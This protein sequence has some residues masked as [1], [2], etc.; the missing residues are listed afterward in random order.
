MKRAWKGLFR[1]GEAN[2]VKIVCLS[3]G[4]AIGLVMLAEVIFER[5]YDNFLPGL[6]ETYRVEERYKQKD[7][8]WREHAQ[9]PGA[10]GPGL[11][12][13]CPAVEVATRFTGI[14]SMTLTTE[15]HKELEGQAWFCDST[16][17]RVFPR[18]LLMGEEPYTGL[19]KANNAYISSKLLEVAG[20]Q[21]I[22]KTLS[23]KQYPEFH[24][25]VVGV[26]EAFP[27]NT[28]LPQMD[29]LIALPTIGQVAYD[30]TNN[31][32]GNDRYKT[33]VRLR[34]GT[35]PDDLKEG[36]DRML[37]ANHVTEELSQS[38]TNLEFSLRPVAEIF[39]SSDYN[40]IMNI[41]FL[42]FAIIMLLV[43]VLNYILL[44]VSSMVSRAKGIAT[45]RCYGAG[46]GDIYRMILS[47]SL[48]H[49]L[50]S[51]ALAVLI[52]F[53]LQDFL[54]EQIGHSLESLFPLSTVWVCLAV[55]LGVILLCGVMPGYLYTRIPVTYAYR[56]YTENKRR[57]K[58]G[59]LCLQFALTAFFVCLLAVIGLEYH[60]LMNFNPGFEYRNTL[61][62]NLS[63]TEMVER[64][65]CVQELK[66]LPEVK[67]V[68]WG[69]QLLS[70]HC[71]GNNVYNPETGEEYMNIADMYYVGPDYHKAFQIPVVEGNVF[72][73]TLTDTLSQQVMVSRRFV[74]RM[75]TLAGWTG[76]PIGK[77]V[78]ITEH[79]DH[80]TIAIV[81]GVYE[82]IHLGSQVMEEYDERPTVMFYRNKPSSY[83][84]VAL[85][86]MSPEAM[87]EVQQVIDRTISSQ[88]LKVYSLSLE[89]GNLYNAVLHVRNSV[90][91]AGLC[92]LIIALTGLVAYVRDEVSRRRSEIAI[93][94]IHGASMADVQKIFLLDLLKIALPAVVI[95]AL[96]AW[97]VGEQLLQLFAVK[98]D[99]TW[100][101]FAGCILIVCLVV[102]LVA[103]GMVW[104]AAR[105]NPTENLKT[106]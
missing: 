101:L 89:M 13:Y 48:L 44:V 19:E 62:T 102:W 24:V 39:T 29:V 1:K 51:L 61:Y 57:W 27:E 58:L 63:G 21:I 60:T 23:W 77:T 69:Y 78:Y 97:K 81:C 47:E 2:V 71:S 56:R 38:G 68:T 4:L 34:E 43:A 42:S 55:T 84:Y 6:K 73:P 67:A 70:D 30:G 17:F 14:G 9:T 88:Q 50:I 32:L 11:Q 10:I 105:A 5:S 93:R 65:R 103:F 80:G 86:R 16:F 82:D 8:D 96:C 64:E 66:K 20:E 79:A 100:Y 91:F 87:K 98:I 31:W 49:G 46:S 26:F 85:N 3:V 25:T 83:L 45:Y 94:L 7:T 41:V 76:S 36:M 18:K 90:L 92:I 53:G 15:D 35:T 22:G 75:E 54:Q 99:L 12:R 72:T 74:E 40:R 37:E 104:K 52:I 106:E 28:H 95:G 33:Y 59:L